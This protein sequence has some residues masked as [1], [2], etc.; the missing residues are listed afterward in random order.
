[1]SGEAWN[2]LISRAQNVI[3]G[4]INSCI[5][6]Y[7]AGFITEKAAGAYFWDQN[8][9]KYVDYLGAWGPVIIG[10]N[11]SAIKEKVKA[12]VDRYD[13][14][15]VGITEPEI[16]LA[17]KICRHVKGV[18][19]VLLCGSG[20]EAT[21]HAIRAARAYVN[22]EKIVKMQGGFH[23]WHDSVLMNVASVPDRMYKYDPLSAGMLKGTAQKTLICRINDLDDF[24][25]TCRK[26]RGEIAA[27]ILDPYSSTLG[28]LKMRRDY[29]S[30]VREI[31]DDENIVL[32][33]D[34]VVTGFRLGL[35]GVTA[36]YDVVPDLV[37]FG[38]A[39]ANGY[40]IA[41]IGG[42]KEIMDT[43]NTTQKGNVS[44]QATYY[45]NPVLAAAAVATLEEL[46]KPGFYEH[47]N[48]TGDLLCKGLREI[49]DRV[50][51]D[52]WTENQGSLIGL[53]WGK[54]PFA[55]YDEALSGVDGN[56]SNAFRVKMIDR[57]HY[58]AI[59]TF[60]RVVT[61]YSHTK[62]DIE[63]TLQVAEDV[64]KELKKKPR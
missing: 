55:N 50:G 40:P 45:G 16:V 34:E 24:R 43:F 22:R 18:E 14:Y 44:Y 30:G 32:I 26:N 62:N 5:R 38:K 49:A 47:L 41:A 12:A 39:M 23:G 15:G 9:K 57:G 61:S 60:K 25:G 10:Y 53:Y 19:R 46:E 36:L 4:G 20:S 7:P 56:A 1:M 13:L 6:N 37:C 11:S 51:V 17:E 33:F 3:P 63:E 31:C 42:S 48:E 8:G 28:C 59:G 2:N 52:F 27:I 35:G 29:I 21:Y 58:F 54:G 64:F